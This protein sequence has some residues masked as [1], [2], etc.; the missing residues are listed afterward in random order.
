[1]QSC[2]HK[3]HFLLIIKQILNNILYPKTTFHYQ[4]FFHTAFRNTNKFFAL[5][6][7]DA[8]GLTIS[9]CREISVLRELNHENIIKL[10][11]VFLSYKEKKVWLVLEYAEYDLWV[12]YLFFLGLTFK[13]MIKH[14]K[15]CIKEKKYLAIPKAFVKSIMHQ[16]ICGINYLHVNWIMHRDLKPANILVMGKGD[17]TGVLKISTIF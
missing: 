4:H 15:E 7:I 17:Q 12:L 16:L 9:A 3:P 6:L 14:R 1:M 8:F 11:Q 10:E 13:H 2:L 5:K